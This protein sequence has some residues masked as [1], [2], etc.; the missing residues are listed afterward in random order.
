MQTGD[1]DVSVLIAAWNAEAFLGTA[2][3][4]ALTQEGVSVE[5]IV[6]DDAS[7]DGTAALV[8]RLAKNDPRIRL[9]S[10]PVNQGP[11]AARN[12]AI[13]AAKGDW[14]AVLDA[15]D[16]FLSGRLSRLV[17]FAQTHE[18]DLA[19][20]LLCEVDL[21]GQPMPNSK[22]LRFAGS[23]CWDLHRWVTDNQPG[24]S[25][26]GTGYLKPLI[27]RAALE[28]FGLSYRE[29]LR[30]SED[31]VLVAE[32][33]AAGGS[34]WVQAEVGYLYTRRT[35]SISHRIGP[36]HLERLLGFERMFIET[37]TGI[38]HQTHAALEERIAA[39]EN[40]VALSHIISQLKARSPRRAL[41]VLL[42]RPQAIGQLCQWI[43]ESIAKRLCIRCLG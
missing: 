23:E 40:T 24:R 19:F 22:A 42:S 11:S 13:A 37:A 33:L 34:V 10:N 16:R 32:L 35:G 38:S 39:L 41:G 3:E 2:I 9:V 30:N 26:M 14:I 27:R 21:D 20:D 7:T 18:A 43:S 25:G 17:A 6:A 36:E 8:Q 12:K 1:V 28:R 29:D 5:V 4:S 15:D 31:Y